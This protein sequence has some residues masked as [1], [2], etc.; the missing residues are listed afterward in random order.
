MNYTYYELY[1]VDTDKKNACK[2]AFRGTDMMHPVD[3]MEKLIHISNYKK[4]ISGGLP[5]GNS[6]EANL[7]GLFSRFNADEPRDFRSMS[8]SDVV[9]LYE[10]QNPYKRSMQ[11]YYCDSIGFTA[12]DTIKFFEERLIK[13]D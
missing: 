4:V 3:N 11:A 13:R 1:Q 6:V 10:E 12:I 8:V 7:E 2:I 9:V 5:S